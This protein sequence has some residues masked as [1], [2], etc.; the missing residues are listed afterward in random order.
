MTTNLKLEYRV[1]AQLKPYDRNAR[2]HSKKQVRQ[3]AD[4]ITKFGFN[5]P[6]LL[7]SANEV[8][9]GHGRLEA[10]KLLGMETVPTVCIDHLSEMERRAYIL[11]DNKLALNA[12]WD[13][14]MLGFEL[15]D[16][17][18]QGMDLTTAGFSLAE[19]DFSIAAA[20]NADPDTPDATGDE[21]PELQAAAVTQLGDV[22]V[23]GHHRLICGDACNPADYE[24][25]LTG[26]RVDLVFTDPPYGCKIAGHVSGLGKRKHREFAGGTSSGMSEEALTS[27]LTSSLTVAS[28]CCRDGAIAYVFMD[29]RGMGALL[30]AGKAAF[31]E[32]KQLCVWNKTNG[33]MGAFYRSKHE[34]VFVFK[35]GTA[36][37]VN[38]FGLGDTGR[39]RTN[40]WDYAGISSFGSD[41]DE[42]HERHP[43][44]K[45][46]ALVADA[47]Q[48]CSLRGQLVLDPFGG[49]GSTLIAAASCGRSARL[50]ELDPLYC[51]VIV[52]RFEQ[53]T[54]RAAMLESTGRSFDETAD[55]R[56]TAGKGGAA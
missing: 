48:D 27:F 9:A 55:E 40:V 41:R 50:I 5:S 44:P 23:L 10:A 13:T 22:W 35:M 2:K 49:S 34:L 56:S 42:E 53:Y 45:P 11:A 39:Y 33:G 8:I 38:T 14:G 12:S 1:T 4:S 51:D 16:L 30:A 18:S 7:T 15:E 29:F 20:I 37:H 47:I 6:I 26:E 21:I 46:V 54:G 28:A 43:T 36:P 52:R 19:I 25:L 17:S 24:K 31:T 32:F 3:I